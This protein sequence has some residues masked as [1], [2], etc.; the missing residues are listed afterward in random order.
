MRFGLTILPELP[1][2]ELRPRWEAAEAMGFDHAWTYDHLVWGGLPESPWYGTMPTLTAAALVTERIGLGTFVSSPNFRHPVVLHRDVQSLDDISE[3]RFIL[4]VGT[5]GDLDSEI[6]GGPSM[7][8]RDR[9]DRFHEFVELLVRLR[10]EDR[11]DADGRW[12]SSRN[13]RTLPALQDVPLVVAANGPRSL[14]LA[15]RTGDAWV[16][17]G[18]RAETVEEWWTGLDTARQGLEEAL[19]AAGRE[20]SSFPRYLNL[21]SSPQYSLTSRGV[22]E[23]MVGRA[24]ALGFTDVITHWPRPEGPY[25]GSVAVLEDVAAGMGSL[26]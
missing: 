23:E 22:F 13:A 14:R 19:V 26:G 1:W 6:L 15:A 7:S 3:G 9:V 8:T 10:T 20:P 16:T 21:D 12:F 11:V 17:T 24:A 25:A 18:P 2:A 5:G 4:G